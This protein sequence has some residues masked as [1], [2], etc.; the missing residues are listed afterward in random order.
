MN[1]KFEVYNFKDAITITIGEV[2][3]SHVGMEKNGKIATNGFSVDDLRRF[4]KIFAEKGASYQLINLKDGLEDFEGKDAATEAAVLIIKEGVNFLCEKGSNY[5]Y[6]EQKGLEWDKKYWD[7]RRKKVLNKN[8]RWNLCYG[9]EGQNAD[10]ENKKGTIVNF[11]AVPALYE[12]ISNVE[13]LLNEKDLKAEG[14]FYYDSKSGIGFHGDS[15]RKKV[16][17]IRLGKSIPLHYQ[18]FQNS[19][20]IGKGMIIKLNHGDIY[21]MSEKA[22]GCDWKTRKIMTLRHA[23]G[24]K[25]YTMIKKRKAEK[26]ENKKRK[27][28]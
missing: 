4:A 20:A 10:F 2:S 17:A 3:E 15:E 25:K 5:V 19:E 26:A 13:I 1:D 14:N 16:I 27:V 9:K 8:A 12:C 18:W 21:V 22:T 28:E 6:E 11:D 23:A 24:A 7:T